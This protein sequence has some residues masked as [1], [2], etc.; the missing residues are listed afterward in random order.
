MST[1]N[2]QSGRRHHWGA[3]SR[4][5]REHVCLA[6]WSRN[7]SLK[8][9]SIKLDFLILAFIFVSQRLMLWLIPSGNPSALDFNHSLGNALPSNAM[10]VS[11]F[12]QLPMSFSFYVCVGHEIEAVDSIR[13]S[14]RVDHWLQSRKASAQQCWVSITLAARICLWGPVYFI[15]L[16]DDHWAYKKI[17]QS[18]LLQV[19][20]QPMFLGLH[21][22]H[23]V[24]WPLMP[25]M[26]V[27]PS[28]E[29]SWF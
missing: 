13:V 15:V 10:A 12:K 2:V 5:K 19:K 28:F 9:L 4:H 23:C 25:Y 22:T 14:M 6:W 1:C 16:D 26:K 3:I 29:R 18:L 8:N 7:N 20:Q 27:H 11:H 21:L 17:S 24:R